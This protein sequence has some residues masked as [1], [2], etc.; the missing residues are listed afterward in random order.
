MDEIQ[1]DKTKK[2]V[3]TND[4]SSVEFGSGEIPVSSEISFGEDIPLSP[5]EKE[6][7]Y[8]ILTENS[9]GLELGNDTDD[10]GSG[11]I[12]I[13]IYDF[14]THLTDE[15]P[16]VAPDLEEDELIPVSSRPLFGSRGG[17]N[18][19]TTELPKTTNGST[20]ETPST[21]VTDRTTR[22]S[23]VTTEAEGKLY[24]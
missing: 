3:T 21:V 17:A 9:T 7:G 16:S 18:V 12:D 6:V 10:D 24:M 4:T 22:S 5:A 14:P 8:A 2:N 20:T 19:T 13:V 15:P 1:E 23:T 11:H